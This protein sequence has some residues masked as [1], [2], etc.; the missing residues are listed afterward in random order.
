MDEVFGDEQTVLLRDAAAVKVSFCSFAK[1]K[2]GKA[3][4]LKTTFG[5]LKCVETIVNYEGCHVPA[6][7][8]MRMLNERHWLSFRSQRDVDVYLRSNDIIYC[9]FFLNYR[10]FVH[11]ERGICKCI[12]GKADDQTVFDRIDYRKTPLFVDEARTKIVVAACLFGICKDVVSNVE[13]NTKESV[14]RMQRDSMKRDLKR[15]RDRIKNMSKERIEMQQERHRIANMDISSVDLHR[16][17]NRIANMD[18]SS[19]EAQQERHRIANMDISSVEAQQVRHRVSNMADSQV[20]N[21]NEKRRVDNMNEIDLE[22]ERKRRRVAYLPDNVR[23]NKLNRLTIQN[24]QRDLR[25]RLEQKRLQVLAVRT[26]YVNRRKGKL[27]NKSLNMTWSIPCPHCGFVY[28]SSMTE[29]YK[30]D[31]CCNSGRLLQYPQYSFQ[32]L[33]TSMEHTLSNNL[34]HVST[35]SYYY[36]NIL[37][38]AATAVDTKNDPVDER[39]WISNF[40]SHAVKLHGRTTHFLPNTSLSKSGIQ[41]FTFHSLGTPSMEHVPMAV[42]DLLDDNMLKYFKEYLI[43]NNPY[44][45]DCIAVGDY[46]T[47]QHEND[48]SVMLCEELNQRTSKFDVGSVSALGQEGNRCVVY[49]V[50]TDEEW[51]IDSAL[52]N[53]MEPLCYPLL[54]QHGEIGWGY[55]EDHKTIDLRT[56]LSSRIL[57]PEYVT[58]PENT[59]EPNRLFRINNVHDEPVLCNRLQA[60]AKLGQAYVTD[61]VSRMI[62]YHLRYH[63]KN[64]KMYFGNQATNDDEDGGDCD[65]DI[66]ENNAGGTTANDPD[67]QEILKND[68]NTDHQIERRFSWA[69]R[70]TVEGDI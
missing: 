8:F 34:K 60:M 37:A 61:M 13:R 20:I 32:P 24:N 33:T 10:D 6:G 31:L 28:L 21:R 42:Q 43:E 55:Q 15:A 57:R 39:K 12:L 30:R 41:I 22:R 66:G 56:Y 11:V 48:D 47:Q 5:M 67:S 4:N 35:S 26:A 1:T 40:G 59:F 64:Q 68:I 29:S 54:F 53:T 17:R 58:D 36:N 69:I 19:V 14:W 2:R 49:K 18:I 65:A 7:S 52:R 63:E 62:D 25:N 38:L 44:V 46:V 50:K 45:R 27:H 23:A 70:F 3:T 16:Q 51:S 9:R